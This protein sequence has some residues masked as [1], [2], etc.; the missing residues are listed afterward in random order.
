MTLLLSGVTRPV[1]KHVFDHVDACHVG[2]G[3]AGFS[4]ASMP[5]LV[6]CPIVRPSWRK[7]RS[8]SLWVLAGLGHPTAGL[9]HCCCHQTEHAEADSLG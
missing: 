3:S 6:S 4:M 8:P 1:P 5:V 7:W 9:E 2:N